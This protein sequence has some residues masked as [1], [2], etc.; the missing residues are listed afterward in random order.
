[1]RRLM[2]ICALASLCFGCATTVVRESPDSPAMVEALLAGVK[3]SSAQMISGSWRDEAFYGECV[4]RGDGDRLTAVLLSSQMR[5]ATLTVERPHTVRWER[6]PQLPSSLDPEDVIFDLCLVIL[7]T[8]EL[9]NALG[10]GYRVDETA[11]GKRRTVAD[12]KRGKL[13]SVRQELPDGGVYFRNVR[14]GYEIT[15]RAMAHE[16][17]GN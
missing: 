7:P 11:D 10:D 13:Q 4:M 14:Y 6:A 2:C 8:D 3:G 15:A 1:M 12:L 16:D 5:L 17:S 9:R